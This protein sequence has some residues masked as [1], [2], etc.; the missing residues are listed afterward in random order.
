MRAVIQR[1]SSA[2]VTIDGQVHGAIETGFM[3]LLGVA[4]DD[5]QA[6]IDYLVRKLTKLRVFADADGK[7]N[8]ALAQVDGQI[9][10]I[11]QFTLFADTRHGNRPG[12]TDA[13]KPD[14]GERLYLAFNSAL[15]AAGITVATGVF[16]ADMQVALVKD[17]PVT[18][19][20][21][22]KHP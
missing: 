4:P 19:I 15:A 21:A 6:D 7:M 8:L 14:L 11:S 22:S 13:A 17:G 2:S 9:L 10:S 3:V 18:I 12:F 20:I 5:T 16:G 1:V